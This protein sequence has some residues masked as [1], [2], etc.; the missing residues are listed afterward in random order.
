M[1]ACSHSA[2]MRTITRSCA[3]FSYIR[4]HSSQKRPTWSAHWNAARP[5][6]TLG[7][8]WGAG[9]VVLSWQRVRKGGA[10]FTDGHNVMLHEFAHQLD[11]EDGAAD[12]VPLLDPPL[13]HATWTAILQS[14]FK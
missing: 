10:D 1:R 13:E 4:G 14:E 7:E 12:G 11:Q 6:P 2:S 5:A 8:S 9:V 3:R